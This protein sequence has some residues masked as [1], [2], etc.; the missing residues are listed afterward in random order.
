MA[1]NDAP[2]KFFGNG[3]A[4]ASNAISLKTST[5][6]NV[7]IGTFTVDGATEPLTV[8]TDHNLK[9]GDRVRLTTT[10]ALPAGF[11]TG[12]DYY[13]VVSGADTTLELAATKG[14]T[15]IVASDTGTGTHSMEEVSPLTE[16]TDALANA[17]TGDSRAVV[18]ALMELIYQ[19]YLGTGTADRPAKMTVSRSTTASDSAGTITRHYSVSVTLAQDEVSISAE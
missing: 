16:L 12:T 17:S 9:I 5:A 18:F 3:Y 6:A 19:K 10:T 2:Q 11:S 7:S 4:L 14:G 8:S 13:V 15:S 1:F